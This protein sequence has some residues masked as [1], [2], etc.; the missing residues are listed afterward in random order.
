MQKYSVIVRNNAIDPQGDAIASQGLLK[1]HR[2]KGL[3]AQYGKP[4]LGTLSRRTPT[5]CRR[6]VLT[7]ME[8]M[9]Q[10]RARKWSSQTPNVRAVAARTPNHCIRAL[11]RPLRSSNHE[12]SLEY[13]E[14]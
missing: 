6:L 7:N 14:Y 2:Q 4:L 5:A 13:L 11:R 12:L 9:G 8:D 10:P 1:P 3:L